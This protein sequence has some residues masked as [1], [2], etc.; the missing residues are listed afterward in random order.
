M[1]EGT[2]LDKRVKQGNHRAST[3]AEIL[4]ELREMLIHTELSKGMFMA[5]HASNYLPLK[6]EIPWG[7]AEAIAMLDA[8]INGRVHL[9]TESLRAL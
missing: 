3:S 8:A 1:C 5:N 2:E 7:K 9:R 4:I 6:V